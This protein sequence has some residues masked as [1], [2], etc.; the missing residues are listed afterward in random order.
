MR[1]RE[2]VTVD[3]IPRERQVPPGDGAFWSGKP[4]EKFKL[5]GILFCV[6]QM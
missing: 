4:L 3:D 6:K 1:G 5:P 2:S